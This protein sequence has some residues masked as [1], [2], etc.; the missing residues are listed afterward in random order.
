MAKFE[1]N[2]I[3]CTCKNVTLGEIIFSIENKK[4]KSINEIGDLTDAGTCCGC[5][6]SK[7]EDFGEEKMDLYIEDILNKKR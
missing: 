2:Y 6:K 3:V 1:F 7:S 5:C 4:A